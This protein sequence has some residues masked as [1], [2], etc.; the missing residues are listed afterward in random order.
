MQE[1]KAKNHQGYIEFELKDNKII[2]AEIITSL[3]KELLQF[4]LDLKG[5][6]SYLVRPAIK[7][8]RCEAIEKVNFEQMTLTDE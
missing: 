2:E 1:I 7:L 8:L 3:K 5:K 6:P 4:R